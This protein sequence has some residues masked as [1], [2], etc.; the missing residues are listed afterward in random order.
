MLTLQDFIKEG[1][2]QVD[3]DLEYYKNVHD[4]KQ[5]D[6]AIGYRQALIDLSD[7]L[8]ARR[9]GDTTDWEEFYAKREGLTD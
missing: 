6:W 3:K 1:L 2:R 5:H 4:N 7:F 9:E 8:A